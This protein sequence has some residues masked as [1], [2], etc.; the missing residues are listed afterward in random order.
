MGQMIVPSMMKKK[1]IPESEIP[2]KYRHPLEQRNGTF[3][4]YTGALNGGSLEICLQSYTANVEHPSRIA[5]RIEDTA[6]QVEI[7]MALQKERLLLVQQ[8]QQVQKEQQDREQKLLAGESSRISAELMRLYRRAKGLNEDV[9]YTKESES[10]FFTTSI[11]LN[12]AVR[13]WYIVRI[14]VLII[15]GYLQASYIMKYMKSR[16][17]FW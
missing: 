10:R 11:L 14:M 7:E 15:S 1:N 5:L 2:I 9:E 13:N 17:M 3:S 4:Y 6:D 16:N 12:H 8:Q